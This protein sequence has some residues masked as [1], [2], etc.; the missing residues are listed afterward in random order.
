MGL[1][2]VSADTMEALAALAKSVA[3]NPKTRLKFQALVR[4]AHPDASMPELDSALA[5]RELALQRE[6]DRREF[7]KYKA[8]NEAEKSEMAEWYALVQEG[9]CAIEDVPAIR[10]FMDKNSIGIGNK[11]FGAE[12]WKQTNSIAEPSSVQMRS[13]EMPRTLMDKM[14]GKG[15]TKALNDTVREEAYAALRDFRSGKVI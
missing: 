7:E 9:V 15:G 10:S 8:E 3:D 11:K 1:E 13:F 5:M 4:E 14:Q 12:S 2:G 6:E